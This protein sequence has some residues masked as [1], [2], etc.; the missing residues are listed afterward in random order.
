MRISSHIFIFILGAFSLQSFAQGYGRQPEFQHYTCE[1]H[2]T[3]C[4]LSCKDFNVDHVI[5]DSGF[6]I[7]KKHSTDK[8]DPKA[9]GY[10]LNITSKELFT[11]GGYPP[12]KIKADRIWGVYYNDTLYINRKLYIGKEGFDKVFCLGSRGYFHSI[13]P[14][15]D[16]GY[17]NEVFTTAYLFG[18]VGGLVAGSIDDAGDNRYGQY[19][20]IMIYLLDYETGMIS[21]LNSFKLEKILEDD[22]KLSDLYQKEKYKFSMTIMHLYIDAYAERHKN[23]IINK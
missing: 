11:D 20:R 18:V 15:A 9:G 19:T 17:D 5:S 1:E 7:I 21:P 6:E 8:K 2:K 23:E 14:H 13:N 10:Q 22:P 4:Y 3:G 16:A 12:R